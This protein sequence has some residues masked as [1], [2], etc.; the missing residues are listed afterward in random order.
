VSEAPVSQLESPITKA[1][2]YLLGTA[3]VSEASAKDAI[4]VIR[5]I[6]PDVVLLELCSSRMGILFAPQHYSQDSCTFI[7]L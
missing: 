3:H 5:L 6:K 7:S 1:K 2:V 4:E